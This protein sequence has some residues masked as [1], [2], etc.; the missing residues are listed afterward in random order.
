[1]NIEFI[2]Y[3]ERISRIQI[4]RKDKIEIPFLIWKSYLN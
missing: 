3:E 1:M 4:K 2:L